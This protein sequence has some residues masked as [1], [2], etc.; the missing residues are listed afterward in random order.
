[1]DTGWYADFASLSAERTGVVAYGRGGARFAG[2]T[3]DPSAIYRAEAVLAHLDRFDLTPA[4]LRAISLR[5]T[6]RILAR[7]EERGRLDDV[8]T[9]REAER[10]GGF[11]TVRDPA[12]GAIVKRL[13]GRGVLVDSRGDRLRLGPAPY[14]TDEEIDRGTLA[15]ID[16]LSPRPG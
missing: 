14:L 1:V 11:V 8:V 10:R 7:F 5:Q 6:G 13:R 12:A 15:V 2:A 3:F 9:P 4:R 16:A